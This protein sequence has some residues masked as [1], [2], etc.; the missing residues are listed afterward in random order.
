MNLRGQVE[1]MGIGIRDQRPRNTCTI[2]AITFLLEYMYS[3]L[4]GEGYEDLSE[5]YLNHME[6]V[7]NG[8]T[9]DGSMFH[10]V[11][12]SY[13]IYGIIH[14]DHL[15][16]DN[17]LVYNYDTYTV[18]TELRLLGMR[19][20]YPGL[21]LKGVKVL[22]HPWDGGT[23]PMSYTYINR[24]TEYL[25]NCIP[26]AIGYQ[27]GPNTGHSVGVV[28]YEWDWNDPDSGY[29]YFLIKDHQ[30]DALYDKGYWKMDFQ[31]AIDHINDIYVFEGIE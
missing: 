5:E 26:V 15:P 9:D 22:R 11:D 6:N 30:S 10:Y 13:K 20:L 27:T 12:N 1:R 28:G 29:G 14:E 3:S 17:S 24:I 21:K 8:Y 18:S 19:M 23:E 25:D 7:A 16:Y 4:F 31:Y 2:F